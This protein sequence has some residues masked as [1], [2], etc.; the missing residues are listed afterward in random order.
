MSRCFATNY[1][2]KKK[3][4]KKNILI[5]GKILSIVCF[6]ETNIYINITVKYLSIFSFTYQLLDDLI[7]EMKHKETE[8]ISLVNCNLQYIQT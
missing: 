7:G 4:I 1:K 2:F 5:K 8:L 3:K 6:I